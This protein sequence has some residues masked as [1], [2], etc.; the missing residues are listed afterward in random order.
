[1]ME[2]NGQPT[3]EQQIQNLQREVDDAHLVIGQQQVALLRL[4]AALRQQ[5]ESMLAMQA[6]LEL[7][8]EEMPQGAPDAR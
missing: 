4:Q 6:K 8:P 5:Q 7:Q 2:Q 3:P 1:M